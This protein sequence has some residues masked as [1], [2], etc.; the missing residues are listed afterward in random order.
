MSWL[1]SAT[2]IHLSPAGFRTST[3][4]PWA[5]AKVAANFIPGVGPGISKGMNM[6][7]GSYN[8]A[9]NSG[10]DFTEGS[11]EWLGEIGSSGKGGGIR[12]WL[13]NPAVLALLAE[14]GSR[15]FAGGD[16]RNSRELSSMEMD[17]LRGLADDAK[18]RRKRLRPI[19]ENAFDTLTGKM[20]PGSGSLLSAGGMPRAT[21]PAYN[22]GINLNSI[23]NRPGTVR[24][25]LMAG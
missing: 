11:P 9:M 10:G 5:A 17:L 20:Q 24:P 13:A 8:S 15:L 25:W 23:R 18:F 21:L 7:Q 3:P 22:P 1:S 6:L 2:G 19:Q 16:R 4:N 12:S 14:G